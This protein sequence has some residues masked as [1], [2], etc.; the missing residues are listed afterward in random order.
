M[1]TTHQPIAAAS[2]HDM[3]DANRF[4]GNLSTSMGMYLNLLPVRLSLDPEGGSFPDLLRQT[5]RKVYGAMANSVLPFDVLLDEL[6]I[7]ARR[8]TA[9]FSRLSSTIAQALLRSALLVQLRVKER[10]ISSD[11]LD[12]TS[13]SISWTI[14]MAPPCS[15]SM[16][17]KGCTVCKMLRCLPTVSCKY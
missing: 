4:E 14:Q 13:G 6:K 12:T 3:A 8:I 2:V 5:R 16:G 17:R 7:P 10:N 11:G 15:C 1:P 9:R